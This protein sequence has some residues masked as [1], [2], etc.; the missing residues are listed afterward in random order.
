M[1]ETPLSSL[2]CV[3]QRHSAHATASDYRLLR[4]APSVCFVN[5]R[6]QVSIIILGLACYE[7]LIVLKKCFFWSRAKILPSGYH[8]GP[9]LGVVQK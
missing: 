8:A 1:S 7:L 9:F 3:S 6:R 4:K 2:H 5:L